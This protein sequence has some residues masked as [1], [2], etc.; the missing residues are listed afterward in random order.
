MLLL[1]ITAQAQKRFENSVHLDLFGNQID[2]DGYGG[3]NH[4]G[5]QFGLGTLIKFDNGSNAVG[6]EINYA[7]KGARKWP[8]IDEGDDTSF[9]L[10]L[11]YVEVPVFFVFDSW[12]IPF[13]IGPLFSY[14]VNAPN[15]R[16]NGIQAPPNM[17]L[18]EFELGGMF[19]LN[20]KISEKLYFKFRITNSITPIFKA[21]SNVFPN[22]MVGGHHRGA[23]LN[24]TY[25]FSSPN[26]K[27]QDDSPAIEE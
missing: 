10:R 4:V 15:P 26:F 3:Y 17:P 22:W 18:R 2:G 25:Y 19:G 7:Q 5:L 23:G 16:Y 21:E 12:G 27:S 9:L 20:Y 14:L 1:T 11:N 24:I 13:E 8:Q 6:F